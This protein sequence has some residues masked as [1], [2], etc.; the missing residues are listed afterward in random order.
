MNGKVRV[1]LVEDNTNFAFNFKELIS[2]DDRLDYLGCASCKDS[3][4]EMAI[5][6]KPDI[7]VMDL[8]LS[9]VALDGIVAAKEIRRKTGIKVL[10]LTAYEQKDTI[11][12]ASKEAFASGYIFKTHF[13]SI[14][15]IIYETA[16]AAPPQKE[17]IKELVL[18][19][20]TVAERD[21]VVGIVNGNITANVNKLSLATSPKTIAAQKTSIF[22]KL[23]LTSEAEL[24][25]I[26][27]NW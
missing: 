6:Q 21:I 15:N 2:M 17:F 5:E 22:K 25:R 7:V 14:A 26:F 13:Q 9:G 20:L 4:V 27:K 11:I 3:G 18:G 12:N 1:L 24:I 10:L 16:T 23:G 8:N 19:E